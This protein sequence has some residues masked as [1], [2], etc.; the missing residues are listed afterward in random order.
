MFDQ[1]IAY[2]Q[3]SPKLTKILFLV[4]S[5]VVSFAIIYFL[6]LGPIFSQLNTMSAEIKAKSQTIKQNLR[7]L[8]MKNSIMRDNDK[9]ANYLSEGN[10]SKEE[11]IAG[12]LH[13]VENLANMHQ[14]TIN[15]IESGNIAENPL[16][17]KYE[18]SVDCEGVLSDILAFMNDLEDSEYLFQITNYRLNPKTKQGTVIKAFLGVSRIVVSAEGVKEL[19]KESAENAQNSATIKT[20][21]TSEKIEKKAEN[22]QQK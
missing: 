18:I 17:K 19:Q 6:V 14:V 5:A 9:V 12:H 4:A 21:Q 11:I 10:L 16:C 8:S 22:V 1:A 2:Y 20:N 13:E 7:M 3:K 15:K